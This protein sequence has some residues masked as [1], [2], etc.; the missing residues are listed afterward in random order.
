MKDK[1]VKG[2]ST[3]A[4]FDEYDYEFELLNS[5]DGL[6]VTLVCASSRELAP[7]EYLEA[8]RSFIDRMDIFSD[9]GI[10]STMH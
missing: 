3:E 10:G 9:V 6:L 8:L 7:E 4:E 1:D 2:K 5:D